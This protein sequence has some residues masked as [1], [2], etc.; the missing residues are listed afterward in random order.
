MLP[1]RGPDPLSSAEA[2][3]HHLLA[4]FR[5]YFHLPRADEHVTVEGDLEALKTLAIDLSFVR[6]DM[7]RS[8][9]LPEAIQ[10]TERELSLQRLD[11]KAAPIYLPGDA[12][13]AMQLRASSLRLAVLRDGKAQRWL[14]LVSASEG[15][16]VVDVGPGQ[17]EVLL[18]G[19]LRQAVA[20]HKIHVD[21]GRIDLRLLGPNALGLTLSIHARKAFLK[22]TIDVHGELHLDAQLNIRPANLTCSGHGMLGKMA[23]PFLKP[24]LDQWESRPLP[25]LGHAFGEIAC[26]EPRITLGTG[27]A[28]HVVAEFG[29]P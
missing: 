29:S 15:H 12:E 18:L 16:A 9:P 25:L 10:A 28:L 4:G 1:L 2:L 20:R 22:G 17:L 21:Q 7:D 3:R 13:F 24:Q 8:P 27:N 26:R 11:F 23:M 5:D 6:V 14:A 19:G